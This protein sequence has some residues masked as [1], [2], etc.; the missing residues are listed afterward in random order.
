MGRRWK[1][2]NQDVHAG[3]VSVEA[4][5]LVRL[6]RDAT[7]GYIRERIDGMRKKGLPP[8]VGVPPD[9]IRWCAA[10]GTGP[11]I[12]D[13]PPCVKRCRDTMDRG[14]NLPHA[15]RF[16]VAAYFVHGGL[17]DQTIG[18]MFAGAPDYDPKVTAQQISQ[19]R[20]RGYLVPGCGCAASNGLC[21]GCD[22]PHPKY[23]APAG[24]S[25][26]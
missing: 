22:A 6:L 15:G 2:V 1:L 4:D 25:G 24:G 3:L 19:I 8:G 20:R 9:I 17:D 7:T 11:A 16:L 14:E 18:G 10:Q 5:G 13:T 26:D 21:P 23:V 12:G